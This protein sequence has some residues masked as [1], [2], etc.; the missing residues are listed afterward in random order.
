MDLQVHLII[1][2]DNGVVCSCWWN[3]ARN[4][5]ATVVVQ[6]E[7]L[8]A[9]IGHLQ[10]IQVEC[11]EVVHEDAFDLATEDVDFRSEDVQRMAIP[12]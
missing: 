9:I 3:F 7:H 8:P 6:H 2:R 1:K 4:R 11:R 12:T 5:S 10:L